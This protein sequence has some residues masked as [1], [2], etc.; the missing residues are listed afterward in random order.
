VNSV[1]DESMSQDHEVGPV[2]DLP[3]GAVV[4][5]GGY[6]VG[7][8]AGE[9]FAVSRRCRHLGADLANGSL[10]EEGRLVCPWHHSAYDVR[11]GRMLRGPQ[12]VFAKVPGLDAAYR[13]LTRVLP[14][15]RGHVLQRDGRLFVR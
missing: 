10:D 5:A 7:N 4:G 12:G 8:I 14:L 9:L 13:A 2:A 6:A 1:D 3:P 11:T 15:R